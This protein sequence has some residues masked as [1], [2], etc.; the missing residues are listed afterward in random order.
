MLKKNKFKDA[1]LKLGSKKLYSSL[2][3]IDKVYN[4]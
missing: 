1:K 2:E 4:L 3:V